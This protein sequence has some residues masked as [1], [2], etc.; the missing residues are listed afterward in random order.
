MHHLCFNSHPLLPA[1][2]FIT[3]LGF[4][5]P[6]AASSCCLGP[7]G[8]FPP[9]GLDSSCRVATERRICHSEFLESRNCHMG[10]RARSGRADGLANAD[11]FSG[12]FLKWGG[13][14]WLCRPLQ[15][16]SPAL[17]YRW[18]PWWK[19]RLIIQTCLLLILYLE[20]IKRNNYLGVTFRNPYKATC[21][22]DFASSRNNELNAKYFIEKR[23]AGLLKIN[24]KDLHVFWSYIPGIKLH[25][26]ENSFL[27]WGLWLGKGQG[28]VR[29]TRKVA[30]EKPHDL[31]RPGAG[32]A[33]EGMF[34]MTEVG[35]LLQSLF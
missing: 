1:S 31:P 28:P 2:F 33:R 35:L 26:R 13:E 21:T 29:E 4:R 32:T 14:S 7:G 8:R 10:S 18:S 22:W 27:T 34:Q 3:E 11:S 23:G 5:F 30:L 12:K 24:L 20:E 6:P 17:C 16:Q 15:I 19:H 9:A 25:E